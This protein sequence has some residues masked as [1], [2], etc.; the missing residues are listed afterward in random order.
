MS[1]WLIVIFLIFLPFLRN[2]QKGTK[3]PGFCVFRKMCQ[4]GIA[5]WKL[6]IYFLTSAEIYKIVL[7]IYYFPKILKK[8]WNITISLFKPDRKKK[9]RNYYKHRS[10]RARN[11]MPNFTKSENKM[12]DK[13]SQMWYSDDENVETIRSGRKGK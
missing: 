5:N 8:W 12:D 2:R 11:R 3:I 10:R 13:A 9:T 4:L 1:F 7:E 6:H